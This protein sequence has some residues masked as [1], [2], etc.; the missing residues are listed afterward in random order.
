MLLDLP[1]TDLTTRSG[2]KLIHKDF[3]TYYGRLDS[4]YTSCGSNDAIAS[5]VI[6]IYAKMCADSILKD[7]LVFGKGETGFQA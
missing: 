2:L 1:L 7:G 5:S 3:Q 6:A 4:V